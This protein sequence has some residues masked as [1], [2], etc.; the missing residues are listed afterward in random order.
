MSDTPVTRPQNSPAVPEENE[1]QVVTVTGSPTGGT[2]TLT[3]DDTG[4]NPQT[5]AGIAFDAAAADVESALEALSN[6]AAPDV[7][8]TGSTGGP[9]TVTFGGAFAEK[10]VA[11]LTADGSS[12]TGGTSPAVTVTTSVVGSTGVQIPANNPN[13]DGRLIS[14]H[15]D[16]QTPNQVLSGH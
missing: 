8:V 12:L 2:F 7:A 10:D 11:A 4:S 13:V 3:F 6:L 14:S 15:R 1:V 5:T 16:D 9:Y